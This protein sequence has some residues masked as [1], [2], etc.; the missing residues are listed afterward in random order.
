MPDSPLV[1]TYILRNYSSRMTEREEQKEELLGLDE[2]PLEIKDFSI[3]NPWEKL[4]YSLESV[5]VAW[6]LRG[7]SLS[8]SISRSP[9]SLRQPFEYSI[10]FPLVKR[11]HIESSPYSLVYVPS[12]LDSV[13]SR[14]LSK[15]S[16]AFQPSFTPENMLSAVF[17]KD[18]PNSPPIPQYFGVHEF[19]YVEPAIADSAGWPAKR[20]QEVL[21]AL[22]LAVQNLGYQSG[23]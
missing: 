22:Q 5:L 6:G 10:I 20:P 16:E 3:V 12:E 11:P 13:P 4:V 19:L 21:S 2:V 14:N 8:P 17:E 18:Q 7:H 15:G 1:L 9:A 23:H